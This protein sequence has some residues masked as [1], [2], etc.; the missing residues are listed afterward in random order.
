ME[1]VPLQPVPAQI[2]NVLLNNQSVILTLRQLATG[3]FMNVISNG[4]E[5]VGLVACQNLNRIVR[6]LY[7]GFEG[8]FVF[9]DNSGAGEDPDFTGLGARYSLIYLSPSD[10]PAGVG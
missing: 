6:D 3:L 5:V 1:I 4:A 7:F 10:L 9:L 2:V 8:D